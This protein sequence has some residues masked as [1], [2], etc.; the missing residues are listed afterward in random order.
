MRWFGGHAPGPA[1]TPLP[2]GAELLWADNPP[3]WT[4]GPWQRQ[5][6]RTFVH[7]DVRLAVLGPCSATGA[8]LRA[9][10]N[11]SDLGST[12]ARWAGSFIAIRSTAHRVE[13]IT[14]ASGAC[15][16]YTTRT[17]DGRTIWGSSSR[18]LAS[19]TGADVNRAWL[20]AYLVDKHATPQGRSAWESVDLVPPGHRLVL[21]RRGS[22]LTRWWAPEKRPRDEALSRIRAALIEGV[23]SRAEGEHVSTDL[24]GMDST[25]LA[26]IS[27]RMGPVTGVTAHPEGVTRGGDLDYVRALDV[28]GLTRERFVITDRYLPFSPGDEEFLPTDEPPPSAVSWAAFSGQLRQAAS[29]GA[30]CHMTGD[31]GDNHFLP[32]PVH[33]VELARD[34][35][36]V[37]VWRDACGWA[38]LRRRTPW[39][40]VQAAFTQNVSGLARSAQCAPVWTHGTSVIPAQF[41][42]ADQALVALIHSVARAAAS[43]TQLA[44]Q[45]GVTQHNPYFD[46]A[47]LDAVVSLPAADRFSV[48]RYKPALV[49]AVGDLLPRSVRE[50]TTKGSFVADYHRG[51][52]T[53]LG[54]VLEL[55]DGPLVGMGLVDGAKLR[56]AVRAASLGART[57]WAHL[58]ATLGAQLWLRAVH[59]SPAPRWATPREEV[60]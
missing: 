26:V 53:N 42:D 14:D 47:V 58:V 4:V 10:V 7:A 59:D 23:R 45:A 54:R 29:S 28:P 5:H 48:E 19:L 39:P 52:R 6:V 49:A 41:P 2:Q 32:P 56:D 16:V 25:T 34:H 17:N 27:A 15:P 31:G 9:A 8:E 36:W 38:R 60:G 37:R 13:I 33:L 35:Q 3:L 11:A 55:C 12:T 1:R 50:R 51:L 40:F 21:D 22:T 30:V 20:A 46:G 24:S 43:D 57:S 18:A 44:D